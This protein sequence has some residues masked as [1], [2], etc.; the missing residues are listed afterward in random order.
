[1]YTSKEFESGADLSALWVSLQ[2]LV[3]SSISSYFDSFSTANSQ[4]N[5]HAIP[6]HIG[7]FDSIYW[8]C[9]MSFGW[10]KIIGLDVCWFSAGLNRA[11]CRP[12]T[13]NSSQAASVLMYLWRALFCDIRLIFMINTCRWILYVINCLL[14]SWMSCFCHFVFAAFRD[15]AGP[16][17][18]G[19]LADRDGF[20]RC[21]SYVAVICLTM[22]IILLNF[23]SLFKNFLE[24]VLP[25][26][27]SH[28]THKHN[29]NRTL[30]A[31]SGIAPAFKRKHASP[32]QSLPIHTAHLHN[33]QCYARAVLQR[34]AS[35]AH[36]QFV[37][38]ASNPGRPVVVGGL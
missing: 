12:P 28:H 37:F 36:T 11:L 25:G 19:W 21:L 17:L 4:Q 23:S 26:K 15:F 32:I 3:C 35:K 33:W 38:T 22:V 1:M 20:P 10:T 8:S 29:T 24:I 5:R 16:A 13:K 34:I 9:L 27:I 31:A 2:H 6:Q 14:D 18:G 30:V 7:R